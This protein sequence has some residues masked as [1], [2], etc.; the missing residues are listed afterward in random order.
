MD[1]RAATA[2]RNDAGKLFARPDFLLRDRASILR[3]WFS[4]GCDWAEQLTAPHRVLARPHTRPPPRPCERER[5]EARS[6]PEKTTRLIHCA[7]KMDCHAAPAARNDAGKLFARPD[8]LLRDRDFF[9]CANGQQPLRAALTREPSR[10]FIARTG[11]SPYAPPSR[12][13]PHAWPL[14]SPARPR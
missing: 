4:I 1:C 7:Q 8:F 12:A 11:N 10:F 13:S 2:A 5:S 14:S 3:D 9:Y 6:N